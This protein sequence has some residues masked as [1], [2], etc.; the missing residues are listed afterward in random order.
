MVL[1]RWNPNGKS[2]PE[3]RTKW[4]GKISVTNKQLVPS[5]I[6]KH[7][8]FFIWKHFLSTQNTLTNRSLNQTNR[9]LSQATPNWKIGESLH[10]FQNSAMFIKLIVKTTRHGEIFD[11]SELWNSK[12]NQSVFYTYFSQGWNVTNACIIIPLPN[13]LLSVAVSKT[14]LKCV[15][16]QV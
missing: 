14:F 11:V 2:N 7:I 9:S 6:C 1:Q 15:N 8:R 3:I 4:N 10:V 13:S 12:N 16:S 5:M